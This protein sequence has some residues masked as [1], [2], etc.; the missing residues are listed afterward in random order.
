MILTNRKRAFFKTI[1]WRILASLDTLLICF[2]VTGSTQTARSIMR[3]E[4]I[5]KMGLYYIHE[6]VW[7]GT[8]KIK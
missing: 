6:R 5:T 4:V 2:I 8:R 1:S 3:V 7:D